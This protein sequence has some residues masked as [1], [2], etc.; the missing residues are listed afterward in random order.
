MTVAK[1][2][3]QSKRLTYITDEK[4]IL[5][6][7]DKIRMIGRQGIPVSGFGVSSLVQSLWS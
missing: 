3:P 4:C 6:G 1:S 2:A 7:S 5:A